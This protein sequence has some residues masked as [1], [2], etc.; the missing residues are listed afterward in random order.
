MKTVGQLAG[1]Y[2]KWALEKNGKTDRPKPSEPQT[3]T[4][5]TKR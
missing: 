1:E 4:P 2:L 3:K 5:E